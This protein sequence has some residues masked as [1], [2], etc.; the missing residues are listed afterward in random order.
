MTSPPESCPHPWWD[1]PHTL[2]EDAP[3]PFTIFL[4]N[5]RKI[6]HLRARGIPERT[7]KDLRTTMDRALL[8]YRSTLQEALDSLTPRERA[9]WSLYL[10]Q[11]AF[12]PQGDTSGPIG[13]LSPR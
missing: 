8:G 1:A 13:P 11:L 10:P 9:R 4:C 2:P 5:E 12:W 7:L 6:A 3:D